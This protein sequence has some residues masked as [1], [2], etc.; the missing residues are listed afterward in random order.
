MNETNK[1]KNRTMTRKYPL[2]AIFFD[3]DGVIIDSNAT[4]SE[5]FRTLFAGYDE[6]IIA[7][8]VTYHQQHG[9]IS[10][11]E[12][13]LHAHGTIIKQPLTEEELAIWAGEY[14]RLVV[15][16]V[17]AVDWIAGA[18]EFL[19]NVAGALPVYVISGTPEEELRH[20]II[21]R[22]MSG[23]FQEILG[24]P[25]RKPEHIRR[26]LTR[27]RLFPEHCLFV[28]DALT[29]F[30]AAKETGLHFIGIQGEAV[31]P[32]GTMVLSDCRGLQDVLKHQFI[33]LPGLPENK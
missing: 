33:R 30:N 31:F 2:H 20:I 5:A 24:S 10:R 15:D 12:K 14:A 18:K 9:G 28:G 7:E 3:F 6:K 26:L 27:Y 11:V 25:T 19:D 23:Y 22:K 16:K 4:K 13:I 32:K 1:Y 21:Q 29:D 8:V 17:I